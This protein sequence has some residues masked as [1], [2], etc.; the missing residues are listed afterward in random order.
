MGLRLVLGEMPSTEVLGGHL[1][2]PSERLVQNGTGRCQHEHGAHLLEACLE[3]EDL[4]SPGSHRLV[5]LEC[6]REEESSVR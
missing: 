6:S 2:R 4:C 3:L 1:S 5:T